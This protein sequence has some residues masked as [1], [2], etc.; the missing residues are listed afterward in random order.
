MCKEICKK[1]LKFNNCIFTV[2]MCRS[3]LQKHFVMKEQDDLV[4]ILKMLKINLKFA[5]FYLLSFLPN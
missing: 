3:V 1:K 4:L 2:L 5:N